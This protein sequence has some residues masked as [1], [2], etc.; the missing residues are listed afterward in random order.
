M[1]FRLLYKDA[2]FSSFPLNQVIP[3]VIIAALHQRISRF[4]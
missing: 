2:E 4:V 1:F 3:S